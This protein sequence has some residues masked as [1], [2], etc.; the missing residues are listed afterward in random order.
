[1]T[2]PPLAPAFTLGHFTSDAVRSSLPFM[3]DTQETVMT[4]TLAPLTGVLVISNDMDDHPKWGLPLAK[5]N[6]NANR[7]DLLFEAERDQDFVSAF[8]AISP[9][10]RATTLA[11]VSWRAS[12][13]IRCKFVGITCQPTLVDK[14]FKVDPWQLGQPADTEQAALLTDLSGDYA[15]TANGW[16]SAAVQALDNSDAGVSFLS[17]RPTG[18]PTDFWRPR[19]NIP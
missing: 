13:K 19:R 11:H 16:T 2:M 14:T 18:V 10:N 5:H 17:S 15:H 3:N 9:Q 7:D 4:L 6:N 8:V 1:M 12:W